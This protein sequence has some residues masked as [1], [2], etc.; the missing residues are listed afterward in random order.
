MQKGFVRKSSTSCYRSPDVIPPSTWSRWMCS[1]PL[2]LP[3]SAEDSLVVKDRGSQSGAPG[4]NLSS[5]GAAG[6]CHSAGFCVCLSY[7]NKT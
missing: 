5:D 7:K 6:M 1:A 3:V 4:S 2:R